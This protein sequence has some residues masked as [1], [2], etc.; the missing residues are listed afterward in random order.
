MEDWDDCDIVEKNNLAAE[1]NLRIFCKVW[2]QIV[3][4]IV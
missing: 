3:F 1:L 2:K 4:N